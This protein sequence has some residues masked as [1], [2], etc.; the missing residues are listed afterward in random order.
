[1]GV[2]LTITPGGVSGQNREPLRLFVS[3]LVTKADPANSYTWNAAAI[4]LKR[5]GFKQLRRVEMLAAV[6]WFEARRKDASF[7]IAVSIASGRILKIV[8]V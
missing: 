3:A 2:G 6:Y 1:M 7:R 5:A 8:R 4:S